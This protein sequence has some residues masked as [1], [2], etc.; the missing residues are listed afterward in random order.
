MHNLIKTTLLVTG[1]V[2]FSCQ[3]ASVI[4]L[5]NLDRYHAS[6]PAI[7]QLE[8][9]VERELSDWQPRAHCNWQQHYQSIQQAEHSADF[10][11][12]FEAII[13]QHGFKSGAQYTEL[14][15][16]ITLPWLEE[17]IAIYNQQL[18]N[19][20]GRSAELQQDFTQQLAML[21][22]TRE[23]ILSCLSDDDKAALKQH[24]QKITDIMTTM[25]QLDQGDDEQVDEQ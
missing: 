25:L 22:Q 3:A 13:N 9:Q 16:K 2:A 5:E 14:S 1:I 4:T 21:T 24:Q 8:Q 15:A 17:V 19:N 23:I 11:S 20:P 6:F 18:Q 10:T 7:H 12:R